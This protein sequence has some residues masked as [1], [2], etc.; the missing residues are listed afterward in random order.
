MGNRNNVGGK[1]NDT[2][3]GV[4]TLIDSAYRHNTPFDYYTGQTV[5]D[6]DRYY[7]QQE[8]YI[9]PMTF[10][11]P[12]KTQRTQLGANTMGDNVFDPMAFAK[13]L[14]M[15]SFGLSTNYGSHFYRDFGFPGELIV[16]ITPTRAS[17]M[18]TSPGEESG[19]GG[20]GT[21]PDIPE[22]D[23]PEMNQKKFL[24]APIRPL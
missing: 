18:T 19:G 24:V 12:T 9:D 22:P 21:D 2:A 10:E 1:R 7:G 6:Q 4:K 15:S 8:D 14:G 23:S 17:T 13:N 16:K 20:G 11:S 3:F 5:L